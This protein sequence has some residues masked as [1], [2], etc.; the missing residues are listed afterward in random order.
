[1]SLNEKETRLQ[2]IDPLLATAGWTDGLVDEEYMYRPGKLRLLG[3]QTVRDTAQFVDYVLRT[4]PRGCIL[5]VVEAKDESHAEGAGLQQALA[6][7]SD[8]AA[9]FAYSSN[10][11]GIVEQDLRTGQVRQLHAFP[12]PDELRLRFEAGATWR[13]VTVTGRGGDEV[14]NPLLQPAFA[15]PGAPA[16]RYYQEHA[17]SAAIEHVLTGRRRA[18]LSLATGTG[19]TF[20]AFNFAYKLLAT[21]YARRILFIADRVS[22]RDQAY[23]EFGGLGERRG[24]VSGPEVPLARDVHFAI[25][26]TLYADAPGGGKVFERYPKGYFDVVIVDECHR[27][28]YGDWGAILEYFS[29]AFHLGMTATPKQDDSID[30]YAFFAGENLDEDGI[31]RPIFE[32]SLGRGIDDGYLAT[33][34]VLRVKTTVDE[35]LVIQEEVERGAELIVP[36]GTTPRDTYEMREFERAIVVPD[37]TRLLCQHLAGV[38]RT[39]GALDKTIVF[40]VTME[41]ADLVR[42]EMQDLLGSETGKNLYAA[43]IVSEERDAGAILEQFQLA[44]SKEPIVV[45]TVDLLST[46][47]NAPSVRNIVFMRPI[48]SVTMFKQIIGR[49]SRV[50]PITGKTY[51]R[52]IDYTNATRLFDDWDLP[53]SPP[54][55]GPMEGDLVVAGVVTD[56]ETGDLIADASIS[57]RLSGRLLAEARTDHDG[58]FRIEELPGTV[59]DVFVTS[60]GYTRRHLRVDA[61]EAEATELEVALRKPS[62]VDHRLRISGVDVAIA[63]EVELDLGNGNVIHSDEYLERAKSSILERVSSLEELRNAWIDKNKRAELSDYLGMRQVTPELLSLVLGRADVDGFDLLARVGFDFEPVS[64]SARATAAEPVLV[65]EFPELPDDFVSAVL[66]KFRLGGVAEIASSELFRLPPFVARWGGI[67]GVTSLLGGPEQVASFLGAIPRALFEP[68][69]NA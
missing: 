39:N 61:T 67:L 2:L 15:L 30:T 40:C 28:G 33:Y 27:S 32:Y 42:S 62:Q 12:T 31:P 45:T 13:G 6:Y 56:D 64:L 65:A 24:V 48:S 60:R 44:S 66:D 46:G 50:D 4:E 11:H 22:L 37:R 35:S 17:V 68:E 3:D 43:R 18:L 36:E 1:M 41:H 55:A 21:G 19:K 52:I 49:G 63:E 8:L 20:I 53:T 10:G 26:Q 57:V 9:P 14:P 25:Y 16:M 54:V 38:L 59:I 69:S 7:A 47:V 34:K 23:N 5:A 29:D 51:F 58:A